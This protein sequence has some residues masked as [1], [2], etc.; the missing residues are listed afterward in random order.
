MQFSQLMYAVIY[1]NND[2]I[3]ILYLTTY[4]KT[5]ENRLQNV[6]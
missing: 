3:A 6:P 2:D 5:R 4:A 1:R